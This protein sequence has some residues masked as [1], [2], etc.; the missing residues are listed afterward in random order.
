MRRRVLG[1]PAVDLT[2]LVLVVAVEAAV[3][4]AARFPDSTEYV[5]YALFL[6]GADAPVTPAVAMRPAPALL[7]AALSFV[8]P[9]PTAYA[10]M[11]AAFWLGGTL[12]AYHL[13]RELTGSRRIGLATGLLFATAD[14]LLYYGASVL[15]TTPGYF[16]VGLAVLFAWRAHQDPARPWARDLVLLALG[17]PFRQE[18]AFGLLFY[19]LVRASSLPRARK[20]QVGALALAVPL[21]AL[22]LVVVGAAAGIRPAS[23]LLVALQSTA[24]YLWTDTTFGRVVHGEWLWIPTFASN[25]GLTFFHVPQ[26]GPALVAAIPAVG[27]TLAGYVVLPARQRAFLLGALLLLLPTVLTIKQ[28]RAVF[29]WWPAVLPALAVGL[30]GLA[31]KLAAAVPPASRRRAAFVLLGLAL[32]GEIAWANLARGALERIGQGGA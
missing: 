29:H 32:T 23:A 12:V 14:S 24:T 26:T 1:M 17:L 13:G 8:M 30:D 22:L 11:N 16:F 28:G 3:F 4:W 9:I 18:A 25:F 31:Q 20:A 5:D 6:R 7:A 15:T 19:L 21:A 27:F 10:A 2:L